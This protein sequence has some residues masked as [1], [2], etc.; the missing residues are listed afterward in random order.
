MESSMRVPK[1]IP[2][3]P[4]RLLILTIAFVM[5][6][7]I[8]IFVPSIAR[9]RLTWF[10]DHVMAAHLAILALEA[11]PDHMVSKELERELLDHAESRMIVM[12]KARASVLVLDLDEAPKIDLRIDIANPSVSALILG[13]I[14]TL[15]R[16]DNRVLY[17]IGPS[18][19][20]PGTV[21][22]TAL[23]EA[24][25]RQAMI[26]YSE[27]IL[28]LSLVI[29]AITAAL[30]Y[31]SLHLLIVIPLKRL[32]DSVAA[33]RRDP[34][35]EEAAPISGRRDEIGLLE[36]ALAEM[37]SGLRA[38]LHQRARLAALGA[39]MTRINHDLRNILSTARLVSDRVALS[40]DP[41]V[42]RQAPMLIAAIDR[43]VELCAATLS[44]AREDRL[45]LQLDRLSLHRLVEEAIA[46][47]DS[48]RTGTPVWS[49]AVPVDLVIEADSV[50][51]LRLLA[52]LA[53]NARE[54]GSRHVRFDA[55]QGPGGVEIE[56]AD[57]GP[58]LPPKARDNLFQPFSGS[59]RPGGTGLGI[60][61]AREIA[62]AHQGDI[63]LKTS[64]ASGTIFLILLWKNNA[65]ADP[66]R[67]PERHRQAG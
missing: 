33:F 43:A 16:A 52:N 59:A 40:Q 23:E 5:L 64:T 6:A 1:F 26:A 49:N 9:Y 27:R 61:I 45:E 2:G 4:T 58:G 62:R 20:M 38:A 60:A 15:A 35:A 36:R 21:I 54:A 53:R 3:L 67:V 41:R 50:Q 24:S 19:K 48:E 44:F 37:R 66:D 57:D 51:L 28:A 11:T 47:A 34:E 12:R 32:A 10:E 17:V 31:L 8:L 22:E 18:P 39:A 63:D 56:I 42:A 13:A 30:V 29:S 55:R 25:L 65:P 46:V 7:E 14:E